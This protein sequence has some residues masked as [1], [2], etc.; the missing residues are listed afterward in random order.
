MGKTRLAEEFIAHVRAAGGRGIAAGA[1]E[2]ETGLTY[3]LFI[4]VLRAAFWSGEIRPF[5]QLSPAVLSELGRLLPE[6]AQGQPAPLPLESPGAQARFFAGVADA[7]HTAL[8]GPSPQVLFLD[9]L[10]WADEASLD[11]LAFVVRRLKDW[12]VMVLAAWRAED[13]PAES[14]ARRLLAE[15]QRS[16]IGSLIHLSPLEAASVC[17]LVRAVLSSTA[18][19]P[20]ELSQRLY[21]ESEG[22]PFFLVEYL[23]LLAS[24]SPDADEEWPLPANVRELLRSRLG[25]LEETAAQVLQSGA[26]IGRSFDFDILHLASGRSE[27]ETVDALE[28]LEARGLVHETPAADGALAGWRSP[29]YVFTHDKLRALVYEETSLAR[30]RLLHRRAAEAMIERAHVPIELRSWAGQIAHH[31]RAAG[32]PSLAAEYYVMAGEYARSLYANRAALD[33]YQSALALNHPTAR[34]INLAIGELHTLHGEYRAARRCYQT[35]AALSLPDTVQMAQATHHLGDLCYRQGAW[36]QAERYYREALRALGNEEEGAAPEDESPEQM[37]RLL[38]DMGKAC[39]HQGRSS[40]ASEL[41]KR[42][43][44]LAEMCGDLRTQAQVHN[45]L[46]MLARSQQRL[47]DALFHLEHSLDLA[48]R[49]DEPEGSIAASNNLALVRA[50]RGEMDEAIVLLLQALQHCRLLGDRHHEAALCNNLAD[51]YHTAGRPEPAMEALKQAVVIFAEIGGQDQ[52]AS[53]QIW[54]LTEW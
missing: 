34:E 50:E 27:E 1:Y 26:V 36:D 18:G 48:G 24:G 40:E 5:E 31:A 47:E 2:G 53:P 7:L 13:L 11:L 54:K 52:Q 46:G 32:L 33:H 41:A 23:R 30:R 35:A 16:G 3:G 43:L 45:L 28:E 14:R 10:H 21:H 15:S 49:L 42:A 29:V 9:D 20:Q 12:P 17:D 8:D 51:L 37:A 22:S 19:S 39:Y 4:E 38:A 25:A 6:L 44:Q